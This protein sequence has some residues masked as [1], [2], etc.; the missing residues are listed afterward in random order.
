[1]GRPQVINPIMRKLFA[2]YSYMG[3][4]TMARLTVLPKVTVC[5]FLSG[6]FGGCNT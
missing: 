1:M 6:P 4:F 3:T 2:P 5:L